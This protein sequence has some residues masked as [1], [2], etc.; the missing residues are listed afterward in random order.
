[1]DGQITSYDDVKK[2]MKG[3]SP[4]RLPSRSQLKRID[5]WD[6]EQMRIFCIR[7]SWVPK[8]WKKMGVRSVREKVL[9]SPG[10][11]EYTDKE[12]ILL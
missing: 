6:D 12:E 11:Y 10:V 7:Q 4:V 5:E 8:L 2:I 9:V 1:M 3:V